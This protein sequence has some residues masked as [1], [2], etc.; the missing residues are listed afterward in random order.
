MLAE[1]TSD[2]KLLDASEILT[3]LAGK[4]GFG[5]TRSEEQP[6]S[7][8]LFENVHGHL[9]CLVCANYSTDNLEALIEHAEYNRIPLNLERA[10]A[11][12]TIHTAGFW[13]CQL[14]TY[15]SPLKANFQLHCKTEKHSQRMNLLAHVCEG[16]PDNRE[17][18]FNQPGFLER[19]STNP[20]LL[21]PAGCSTLM[22]QPVGASI[23]LASAVQLK[24][25]ACDFSTTSVHKIRLHCQTME[26]VKSIEVFRSILYRLQAC[27]Q[28]I[29][30]MM[31]MV[32]GGASSDHT[33]SVSRVLSEIKVKLRCKICGDAQSVPVFCSLKEAMDHWREIKHQSRVASPYTVR[34][35]LIK[36]HLIQ[37][38][39]PVPKQ[40]K[41]HFEV[42]WTYRAEEGSVE[43]L[44]T[45]L[46][47]L[48]EGGKYPSEFSSHLT[49][50]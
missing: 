44:A 4:L 9:V 7:K 17:R 15:K 2:S 24:C 3:C 39:H 43:R 33:N 41:T 13:Y 25:L 10:N 22:G 31:N 11:Y 40:N 16:G 37:Q 20:P 19:K 34:F 50:A 42:F 23:N 12:I 49:D 47:A 28:T 18:V 21:L 48:V 38:G 6:V 35:H 8:P 1:K 45:F 32:A 5:G 14:C 26:H 30:A 29:K 46:N 36:R 27:E